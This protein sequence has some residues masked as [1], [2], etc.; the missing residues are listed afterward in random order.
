MIEKLLQIIAPDTCAVCASEGLCLCD[1][2][3]KSALIRKKP[4]CVICNSLNETGKTCNNCY[5]KSKLKGASV[6]YRYEGVV[7]DLV[8][9]MKYENKRSI[10]RFFADHLDELQGVVCY[11]PSD[12]K[13]RRA[14]GYDQAEILASTY[15]KIHKLPFQ[16]LLVRVKH[17]RQVGKNRAERIENIKDNFVVVNDVAGKEIILIDDVITTGATVSECARVLNTAG[18]KSVWAL[19]IAKK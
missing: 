16:R 9:A 12:G 8:W 14:R 10:A 11:V 2:C 4:A 6:S 7:K 15:A 1:N 17:T 18:A 19:A 13:T 3:S 5:A